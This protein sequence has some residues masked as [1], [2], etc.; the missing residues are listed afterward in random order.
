MICTHILI[1]DSIS[2]NPTRPAYVPPHLRG[3]NAPAPAPVAPVH[4]QQFPGPPATNGYHAP[5]TGLPT[6]APT[7]APRGAYVPPVSRGGAP[8]HSE[9]GGWGAPQRRAPEPRGYGGGGGGAP[10]GFGTWKN[11]HVVGAR[12]PRLEAELFG[13]EGDGAHQVS[14]GFENLVPC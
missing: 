11:G 1:P 9:D 3:G 7:P 12:N 10:P 14:T 13:V 8:P 2:L 5:P 6:P 4:A